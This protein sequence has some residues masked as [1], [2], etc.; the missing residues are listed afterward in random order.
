LKENTYVLPNHLA[1]FMILNLFFGN[2][3]VTFGGHTQSGCFENTFL[4]TISQRETWLAFIHV[5][6]RESVHIG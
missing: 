1:N 6:D 4:M 2:N 3:L 5:H